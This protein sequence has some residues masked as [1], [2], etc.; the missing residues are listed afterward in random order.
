MR[1]ISILLS[2]PE[3]TIQAILLSDGSLAPADGAEKVGSLLHWFDRDSISVALGEKLEGIDPPW[4]GFNRKISWGKDTG[5]EAKKINAVDCLTE[6]LKKADE[7][8]IL[9]CLG[10]LTNIAKAINKDPL[11]SARIERIIWY[12]DSVKPLQGFNY[13]CDR[14]SAENV[15][16]SGIRVDIISNLN[17]NILF[18]FSMYEGCRQSGTRLG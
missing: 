14:E 5:T 17:K 3:I 8:I 13:E 6:S 16:K 1:A 11:L 10:P 9:V 12:N 15:F 18:D 4:R 2:R 7:K